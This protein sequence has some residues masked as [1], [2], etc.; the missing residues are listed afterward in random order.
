MWVHVGATQ[1]LLLALN[2]CIIFAAT[3]TSQIDCVIKHKFLIQR[4]KEILIN[5]NKTCSVTEAHGFL[6]LFLFSSDLCI[7]WLLIP[8]VSQNAELVFTFAEPW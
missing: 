7:T 3:S 1:F 4:N 2:C 8:Y 6:F 5:I